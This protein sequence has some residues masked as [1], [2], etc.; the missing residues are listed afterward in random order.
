MVLD[1]GTDRVTC[2]HCAERIH[3][4]DFCRPVSDRVRQADEYGPRSYIIIGRDRLLHSCE[5][6]EDL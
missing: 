5:L 1:D 2:P 4:S 3:V 6:P